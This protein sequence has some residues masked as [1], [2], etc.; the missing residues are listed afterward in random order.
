MNASNEWTKQIKLNMFV[1]NVK[2]NEKCKMTTN[3]KWSEQMNEV[4]NVLSNLHETNTVN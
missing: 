3:T 4:M 2:K 1:A